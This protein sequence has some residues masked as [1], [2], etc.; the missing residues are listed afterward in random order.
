MTQK[1]KNIPT[2]L[3]SLDV[4]ADGPCPGLYSMLSFGLVPLDDPSRAFYAELAPISERYEEGALKACGFTRQQ[5]LEFTP[6]DAAMARFLRWLEDEPGSGRRVI[7]SDNPAFDWQFF[8]YY[9]HN[10]LGGNPFG[11]SA[12]R[13]GDFTSGMACDPRETSG[14]KRLRTEKHTHNALD[15]AR[16]NAG[17]LVAILNQAHQQLRARQRNKALDGL[18]VESYRLGGDDRFPITLERAAQ[19][20]G[21][22][23]WA[24][25]QA[26][27][28]MNRKGQ[29]DFEPSPSNRTESFF[30]RFRWESAEQAAADW[31]RMGRPQAMDPAPIKAPS[32]KSGT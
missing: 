15:D 3:Y 31:V 6:A 25:R 9:C 26:G 30:K 21:P 20:D 10:F 32:P 14:W 11:H 16:G 29:W 5:T 24:I 8:N 23:R 18:Q 19:R 17:A 2:P 27:Q 12:R 4:E 1:P 13:I 22:D 7:W 28:A